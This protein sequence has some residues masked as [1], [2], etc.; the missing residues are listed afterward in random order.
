MY[1]IE[2]SYIGGFFLMVCMYVASLLDGV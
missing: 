1:E 2:T